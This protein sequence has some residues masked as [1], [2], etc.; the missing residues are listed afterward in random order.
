MP[1][2]AVATT[3]DLARQRLERRQPKAFLERALHQRIGR[4][5]VV[6]QLGH[7]MHGRPP[8]HPL[9]RIR[10]AQRLRERR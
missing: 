10:D 2:T 5:Q 3:G 4:A 1:P 9:R 8:E 6:G 7:R